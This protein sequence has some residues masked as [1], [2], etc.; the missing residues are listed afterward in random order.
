MPM[1]PCTV[2]HGGDGGSGQPS[3]VTLPQEGCWNVTVPSPCLPLSCLS[4][5]SP[6]LQSSNPLF[7][8]EA[9][10]YR[11]GVLAQQ[12]PVGPRH[13]FFGDST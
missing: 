1:W 8:A 4:S 10:P 12:G 3:I 9:G 13:G 6:H 5:G 7:S 2:L 11:M